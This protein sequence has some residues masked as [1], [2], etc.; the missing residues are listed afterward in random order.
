MK[1]AETG[2][3]WGVVVVDVQGDFT[4]WKRGALAVPGSGRDYVGS[5]GEGDAPLGEA[6]LLIVG[7]QDWHPPDH[8]SFVTTHPGKR[9]F[10]TIVIDGRTQVLWP[11]HCVQGTENAR[12]VID[13]G[14]FDAI[15]R[16][17]Q[18]RAFDSYSA[19][20]DDGGRKTGLDDILKANAVG[21]L[22]STA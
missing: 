1:S 7:S 9:P 5:R 4:E 3:K 12:I 15:V 22:S 14:L 17:A 11:P 16:K 2:G 18:D 19:F 6:G 13:N 10:E 8:L 20:Q 21:R